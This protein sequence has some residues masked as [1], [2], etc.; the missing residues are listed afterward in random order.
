M[1]PVRLPGSRVRVM[2]AW[3]QP[4]ENTGV[5]A[6]SLTTEP[7]ECADT[8]KWPVLDWPMVIL[9]PSASLDMSSIWMP[10]LTRAEIILASG[11]KPPVISRPSC[12]PFS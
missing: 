9:S 11:V 12:V 4:I 6:W 10:Y 5:P 8:P 1:P 7:P 3:V 2:R